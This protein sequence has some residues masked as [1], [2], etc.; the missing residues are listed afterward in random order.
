M[1]KQK[2]MTLVEIVISM[3]IY[4]LLALL[5]TEIMTC[6]NASMR[7]TRQLNNRLSYEAKF[8]DN[9][10]TT[11]ANATFSLNRHDFVINYDGGT[12]QINDDPTAAN[13]MDAFEWTANMFDGSIVG[14]RY[15]T[16]INYRF[17]KFA[18]QGADLSSYP[19]PNYH[20]IIRPVAYFSSDVTGSPGLTNAEM[21]ALDTRARD[22][23]KFLSEIR[24]TN[25]TLV[26]P[27]TDAD[28]PAG[29]AAYTIKGAAGHTYFEESDLNT[30]IDLFVHNS[31]DVRLPTDRDVSG[32]IGFQTRARNIIHVQNHLGVAQ[33]DE[34]DTDIKP[35]SN[36]QVTYHMYVR[37]GE[38]ETNATYY[39]TTVIEYNVLT[40]EMH[41]LPA[42]KA[43]DPIPV[44][45]LPTGP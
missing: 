44:H 43:D 22:E 6:V 14:E 42:L 32:I 40:G 45:P 35:Y 34:R 12:R 15:A 31:S 24:I 5:L 25:G 11:G 3:A 33:P 10:L 1:K 9:Q 16:D 29:D 37:L 41:A 18:H 39:E 19:G 30:D 36:P 13:H 38:S 8:A 4:G 26:D 2:G 27:S 20:L 28:I 17:M 7:A 21:Q 23:I